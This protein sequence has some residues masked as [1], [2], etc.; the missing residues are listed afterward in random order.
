MEKT[1][2]LKLIKTDTSD[3]PGSF[4]ADFAKNMELI[5]EFASKQYFIYTQT[6]PSKDWYI[7]HNLGR[8]PS[9]TIVDTAD[10]VVGGDIEYIDDNSIIIRFSG[11]FSGKAYLN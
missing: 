4:V 7:I 5:D 11:E 6:L 8:K 3:T 2:T 9:V 1:N 10:S